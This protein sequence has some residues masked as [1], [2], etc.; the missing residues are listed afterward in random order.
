M[1]TSVVESEKMK[2]VTIIYYSEQSLELKHSV[3]FFLQ[4]NNGRVVIPESYK[5]NKSI[6]AVCEGRVNILNK[7]G[8]RIE[9]PSQNFQV[10]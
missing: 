8:E 5:E 2:E 3:E 1:L 9:F 10:M 7:F 4:L 6:I